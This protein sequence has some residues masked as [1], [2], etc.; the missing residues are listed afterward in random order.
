MHIRSGTHYRAVLREKW[1]VQPDTRADGN[2][3]NRETEE[4]KAR[5][6][7]K[8]RRKYYKAPRVTSA[9]FTIKKNCRNM[10]AFVGVKLQN[11][12]FLASSVERHCQP[13]GLAA[14]LLVVTV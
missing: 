4:S 8:H 7:C 11:H 5:L 1:L 13:H 10:K 3:S 2:E 12:S 9:T 6:T 14:L